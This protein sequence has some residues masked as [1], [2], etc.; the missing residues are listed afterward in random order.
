MKRKAFTLIE[1]LVVIAIIAILIG[2]LLPAVQKVREAAARLSCTN[3]EKQMGLAL[4]SY[5]SS[6]GTFPPGTMAKTRFS[7]VWNLNTTGG[8]EWPYFIHY[9][10][11]HMEQDNFHKALNGNNF[12]IPNPWDQPA[13]WPIA[14]KDK[15]IKSLICSSDGVGTGL[16]YAIASGSV[17]IPSSNYLGFFSGLND[18]EN[19]NKTFGT[20]QGL[21]RMGLG[22]KISE[23]QDGTSNTMAVSEYLTGINDTDSRGYFVTN[24][25]GSQF[26]YTTLLPNSTSPDNIY[27]FHPDFCP[28]D[29]SHNKPSMNLPCIGGD[30]DANYASPRSRHTGGVNVLFCDGAVRFVKNAVDITVWRRLGA[31]ADGNPPSDF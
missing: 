12:D 27:A 25:A 19:V 24:R 20:Q 2:L 23:I 30:N 26:L 7:Y 15:P 8:Y 11:P 21:F 13:N 17:K 31:I 29:N 14:A 18:G 10:M 9:L 5:L 22:T 16:K 28:P 3:N 6:A 1:L 4:H